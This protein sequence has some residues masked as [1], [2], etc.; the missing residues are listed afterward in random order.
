[1]FTGIIQHLGAIK[2][3]HT[4]GGGICFSI[5]AG[6]LH[7]HLTIGDSIA[8]NGVCLTVTQKRARFIEVEAVEE[9][10]KKTTLGALRMNSKINC[11]LPLRPNDFLGGHFVLGHVDCVGTVIHIEQRPTSRLVTFSFSKEFTPYLIPR[12]SVAID[13]VSLTVVDI[14]KNTFSVSIIPHT[15]A[16][17][18]FRFFKFSTLVNL[19]FDMLGKY[20]VQMMKRKP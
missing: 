18:N 20:V 10:L 14:V 8:I 17:T 9:T 12:G 15:F 16:N 19:E 11:E 13:G 1:M 2:A 5:D 6:K 4:I 3:K 7:Q